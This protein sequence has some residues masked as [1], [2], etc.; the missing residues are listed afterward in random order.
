MAI[1][2]VR[3]WHPIGYLLLKQMGLSI[4]TYYRAWCDK[5]WTN[6][7]TTPPPQSPAAPSSADGSTA[8]LIAVRLWLATCGLVWYLLHRWIWVIKPGVL[9]RFLGTGAGCGVRGE[10]VRQEVQEPFICYGYSMPEAGALW[11]KQLIPT[12]NEAQH[13]AVGNMLLVLESRFFVF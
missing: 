9:Q 8:G 11:Q 1:S 12:N 10:Q 13:V 3:P 4:V 5:Q 2:A 7:T 6:T